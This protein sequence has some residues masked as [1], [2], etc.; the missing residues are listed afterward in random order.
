M[1]AFASDLRGFYESVIYGLLVLVL[2]VVVWTAF[3][4]SVLFLISRRL[5]IRISSG[6]VMLFVVSFSLVGSVS[7]AIAGATLESIVGAVLAA[8]LGLVSSLLTYLFGK[9]NLRAWHPVIPLAI[10]ALL[11]S[12]LVGLVVGGSRRTQSLRERAAAEHVKFE[13]EN[14][15]VPAMREIRVT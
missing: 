8:I 14:A 4:A 13:F 15:D 10:V 1:D 6:L 12:T 5:N 11:S 9:E 7:G 3:L 2:P